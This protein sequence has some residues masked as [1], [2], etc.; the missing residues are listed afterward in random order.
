MVKII[1]KLFILSNLVLGSVLAPTLVFGNS[2][3]PT[4]LRFAPGPLDAH[5]DNPIFVFERS[6]QAIT[7][8]HRKLSFDRFQFIHLKNEMRIQ[9]DPSQFN[10][11]RIVVLDSEAEILA[12]GELEVSGMVL[13]V[14]EDSGLF[15]SLPSQDSRLGDLIL[16]LE[17]EKELF[18]SL[19][20]CI[21]DEIL[22]AHDLPEEAKPSPDTQLF[23]GP[24]TASGNLENGRFTINDEVLPAKGEYRIKDKK[25]ELTI[26]G[27]NDVSFRWTADMPIAQVQE[28]FLRPDGKINLTMFNGTPVGE[29]EKLT[30]D[31]GAFLEATIG[32]LRKFSKLILP[33]TVPYLNLL[34]PRGSVLHQKLIVSAL[35]REEDRL[36]LS[37]PAINV[38][39]GSHLKLSGPLGAGKILESSQRHVEVVDGEYIWDFDSPEKNR[40]NRSQ[41][42]LKNSNIAG[43]KDSTTVFDYEVFRG[44]S[45]YVSG[46]MGVSVNPSTG[47]TGA[48][49]LNLIHWFEDLGSSASWSRQRWGLSLGYMDTLLTAKKTEEYS[50]SYADIYYRF[51]PGVEGWTESYGLQ[52]S[53]FRSQ[54]QETPAVGMGGAGI[55]WNRSLPNWFN[56]FVGWLD[57]L[58][59]PKWANFSAVYY[60][61]PMESGSKP[62]GFQLKAVAR[63]DVSDSSYFEGGWAFFAMKY[64]V[65]RARVQY[66]SGRAYL[67][68]GLRF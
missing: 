31:R 42:H 22:P 48:M 68:Y 55:F 54:Y 19:R 49:D 62:S 5:F 21:W 2:S 65:K 35:P 8:A 57:F 37:A 23:C 10:A 3:L 1:S 6:R 17:G 60:G 43:S 26:I 63:I 38:T 11:S 56:Y 51:T 13:K 27:K 32:D 40:W 14:K 36:Y 50:T 20:I 59:K 9:W 7:F 46:R 58:K 34:G 66:G 33:P 4:P 15:E 44:Y 67:G 24:L 41:I 45:T 39:Y 30:E 64:E 53:Y 61:I 16:K 52:A 29:S 25:F 28:V 47:A 12:E 18:S